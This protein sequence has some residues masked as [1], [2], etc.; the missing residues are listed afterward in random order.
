MQKTPS[1]FNELLRRVA[2]VVV[3]ESP[4]ISPAAPNPFL[5]GHVLIRESTDRY[6]GTGLVYNTGCIHARRDPSGAH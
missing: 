4:R 5:V 3:E 6:L 2:G 1:P